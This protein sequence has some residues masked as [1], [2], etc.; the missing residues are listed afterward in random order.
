MSPITKR[1]FHHNPKAGKVKAI[2]MLM[3]MT[4]MK[5]VTPMKRVQ[6]NKTR[7]VAATNRMKSVK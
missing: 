7:R 5:K 1:V 3:L 2:M 6:V 4:M